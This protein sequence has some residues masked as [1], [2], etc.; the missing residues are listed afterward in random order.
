[1]RKGY[2]FILLLGL[3]LSSVVWVQSQSYETKT[4]FVP[5][6]LSKSGLKTWIVVGWKQYSYETAKNY[7]SLQRGIVIK[8][9]AELFAVFEEIAEEAVSSFVDDINEVTKKGWEIKGIR[10]V[11]VDLPPEDYR[12]DDWER[13]TEY[14]LQKPMK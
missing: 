1:M 3:V 9:E 11:W 12:P 7:I 14:T 4:V 13:G 6:K 8:N 10:R 2:I 5:G